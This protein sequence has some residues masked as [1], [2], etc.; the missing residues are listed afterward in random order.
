MKTI[1]FQQASSPII[2]INYHQSLLSSSIISHHYHQSISS[3]II[4]NTSANII[5]NAVLFIINHH[6]LSFLFENKLSPNILGIGILM[7][8][9]GLIFELR[10]YKKWIQ[11]TKIRVCN[12]HFS[13]SLILRVVYSTSF[14]NWNVR[15]KLSPNWSCLL[16]LT[17]LFL[18]NLCKLDHSTPFISSLDDHLISNENLYCN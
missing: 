17:K 3:N 18:T 10:K 7:T 4:N 14:Q 5:N 12:S 1:P 8:E 2:I 9:Q 15:K 13:K 16:A 6:Q 11:H